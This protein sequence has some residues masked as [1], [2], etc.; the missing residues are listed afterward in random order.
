[1]NSDDI[2]DVIGVINLYA[3]TVDTQQWQLFDRVFTPDLDANCPPNGHWTDLKSFTKQ[4]I[5]FHDPLLCS[6]HTFTNHNVVVNGD[7]ANALSYVIVRLVKQM[8]S[9]ESYYESAGWYDDT[10]VRTPNGWRIRA[11]LYGGNWWHGNPRVGG[12]GFDPS[13]IPLRQAAAAG[14][15]SYIKA[16]TAKA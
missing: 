11:R 4:W 16:L 7:R 1:M 15:L 8:P 9:G 2:R 12:D 10:L 14:Q 6:T 5:D 13:I 3:L